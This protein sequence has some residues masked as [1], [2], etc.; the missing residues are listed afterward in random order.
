MTHPA[1]L[2]ETYVKRGDV[3]AHV[4]G[5]GAGMVRVALP[6]DEAATVQGR[7]RAVSLRLAETGATAHPASLVRDSHGA[8]RSL[9]SPALSDRNGGAIRTDPAVSDAHVPVEGL[10]VL[11]L[12]VDAAAV[13]ARI[14]Q[15]AWVRFDFGAEPL[16]RQ[17]GRR[18]RKALLQHFAP[19]P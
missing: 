15:R 3:L 18:M 7:T 5:A 13:A 6:E 10:V 11:D 9:P 16:A 19:T 12:Q 8:Q 1:D 2:P 4:L 17:W 14:G